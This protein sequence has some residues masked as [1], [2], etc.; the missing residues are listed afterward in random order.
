MSTRH[1]TALGAFA[2]FLACGPTQEQLANGDDPIAALG[3]TVESSR[4]GEQ[5]WKEQKA[6]ASEIWQQAISYCEPSEHANYPNC[7]IVT[8][9]K[10]LGAP[11][12]VENPAR[13]EK[14]LNF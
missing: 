5:Y 4:Y 14:G 7:E 12:A 10:F 2:L 13:S 8:N 3:A 1:R 6:A 11:E 9:V